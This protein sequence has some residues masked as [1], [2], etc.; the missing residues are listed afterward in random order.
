[1]SPLPIRL[2]CAPQGRTPR[3]AGVLLLLYP[4]G[5]KRELFLVLT[6]RTDTLPEHTGQVS[7]PGGGVE[8]GDSSVT[9]TALRETC[10]EIG[11]CED[12]IRILGDLSAVY[13]EPTNYCIH[14]YVAYVAERPPFRPEPAEVA[15]LIEVPLSHLLDERNVVVE[16]WIVRDEPMRVPYFDIFGHRVWGATAIILSEFLAV[17]GRLNRST[18]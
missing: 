8:P 6:R 9:H 3:R 5:Q 13:V 18:P 10:E 15:E 17:L 1:M 4:S 12:G 14:P 11:V 7:L 16:D 2:T